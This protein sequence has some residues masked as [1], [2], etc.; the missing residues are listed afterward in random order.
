MITT[1]LA[2][3]EALALRLATHPKELAALRRRLAV[4]RASSPLFD[5]A[6]YARDFEDAMHRIWAAAAES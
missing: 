3:Y 5:M 6:R 4:N 2:D 1:S